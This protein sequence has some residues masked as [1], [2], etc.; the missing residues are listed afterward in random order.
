MPIPLIRTATSTIL[1]TTTKTVIEPKES[2]KLFTHPVRHVARQ[3]IL[4]RTA[5]ME[6]M[7]SLD[8]LP[9]RKDQRDK[10]RSKKEP[11]KMTRMKLLKLQPKK[12]KKNIEMPLVHSGAAIDRPEVTHITLP[13]ISEVVWQQ[14]QE[15]HLTNHRNV[16]TNE[17]YKNTHTPKQRKD[18]E[19]QTSPM[20][21]TSSQVS[22][23]GTEPLLQNQTRSITV[24]CPKDSKKQQNENQ[25]D[26]TD[27]AAYGN[28]DDNISPP[29]ITT[30][31]I[32]ER[33]MKDDITNEIYMPLSSTIFL[34]RKKELLYVP[35]D[36]KNG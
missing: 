9:G 8:R 13:P 15:T 31:Q 6:P 30:S 16:L 14:P 29:A 27:L 10:I 17:T 36:F 3:T 18:V 35:L 7:H 20:K 11:I 22:G 2:Q 28:G 25:P 4:K 12:T 21:E 26:E 34:K 1:T 24:Q 5:I 32:K 33:L 19:A 23:S